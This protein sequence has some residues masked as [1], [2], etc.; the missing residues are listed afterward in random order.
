MKIDPR[1]G[2][3]AATDRE[4]AVFEYFLAEHAPPSAEQRRPGAPQEEQVR[5]EDL[6]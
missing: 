4:D 6:F 1:T 5:P 3:V 2:Q